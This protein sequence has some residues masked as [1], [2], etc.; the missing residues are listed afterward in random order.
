[1]ELINLIQAY[2]KDKGYDCR[3]TEEGQLECSVY[4]GAEYIAD[5]YMDGAHVRVGRYHLSCDKWFLDLN[6]PEV[7]L[8][9]LEK[10]LFEA[11]DWYARPWLGG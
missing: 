2:L 10:C 8:A 6:N 4:R 5:I 1:M 9:D 7:T 3:I 11:T